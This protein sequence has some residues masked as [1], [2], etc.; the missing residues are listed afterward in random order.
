MALP[1]LSALAKVINGIKKVLVPQMKPLQRVG[2]D[3]CVTYLQQG[4]VLAEGKALRLSQRL[5]HHV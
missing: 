3:K 5:A 2:S 1:K 4:G